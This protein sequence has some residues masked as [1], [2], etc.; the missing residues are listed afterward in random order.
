MREIKDLKNQITTAH[1]AELHICMLLEHQL[2]W[3][4]EEQLLKS[5]RV[6][7]QTNNLLITEAAPPP[8]DYCRC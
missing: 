6:A 3:W 2:K 7:D 8:S 4:R 1:S 5:M